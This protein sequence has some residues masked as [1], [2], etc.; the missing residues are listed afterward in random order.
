MQLNASVQIGV[1]VSDTAKSLQRVDSAAIE[2]KAAK[3]GNVQFAANHE[4]AMANQENLPCSA[5]SK[6][7]A[8]QSGAVNIAARRG[9]ESAPWIPT[10]VRSPNAEKKQKRRRI[11]NGYMSATGYSGAKNVKKSAYPWNGY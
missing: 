5:Q 7:S 1:L 2:C 4:A 9:T 6:Q 11:T 3:Y 8:R 10:T